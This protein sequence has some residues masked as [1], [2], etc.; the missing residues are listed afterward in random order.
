MKTVVLARVSTHDQEEGH[1]IA[2]QKDRLINASRKL[3]DEN[4]KVFEI[5]E[6]STRGERKEFN[7]MIDYIKAQKERVILIADAV[8][9]VQRSFKE[10]VMLDELVRAGKVEI[11]FLRENLVISDKATSSQFMLWDFAVIGAK[12]YVQQLSDNVKRSLDH[13]VRNGQW[14]AKAPLGYRNERDPDTTK[15]VIALDKERDYLIKKAFE[16]YATG[17]YSIMAITQQMK[18]LGLTNNKSP[19]KP[20]TNSQ[21][22][23]LLQNPFYY[24]KMKVKDVLHEHRHPVIIDEWLFAKCQEVRQGWHK[25]PFKYASKPYVF[26]GLVK[27]GYCGCA[28]SS[29]RKKNK[30]TYLTCTKHKGNCGAVRLREEELL[31]QVSGVLKQLVIPEDILADLKDRLRKS[32]QAKVD[33]HTTALDALNKQYSS[34]QKQLDNLLDLRISE[35]ITTDEYDKK[36][37]ELKQKQYEIDLKLRQYSKADESFAT[38]VSTLLDVT[39]RAYAI[40]ESSKDERKRQILNFLFSNLTLEGKKLNFN[41]KAPFDAVL[42]ASNHSNWLRRSDS[43]RRRPR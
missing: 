38:T 37:E 35:R 34:F 20:I 11:H 43:N 42:V 41:L 25:K 36:A 29:D 30:Y 12:S 19:F 17:S 1:S 8:D 9:R 14:I 6:S 32:H 40:F 3:G 7:L 5:I 24:G 15:S 2:A 39:S 26:R 22:H 16:L 4:P 28:I 10:S 21:V 31:T 18:A 33:Y 23:R 13:K 27:C